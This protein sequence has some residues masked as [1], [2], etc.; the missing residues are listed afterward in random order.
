MG[1]ELGFRLPKTPNSWRYHASALPQLGG[2]MFWWA[3]GEG[4]EAEVVRTDA[5]RISGSAAYT[6]ALASLTSFSHLN[7]DPIV[8]KISL[9]TNC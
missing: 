1:F 9:K 7:S 4:A 3:E 8:P 5:N 2:L 6:F